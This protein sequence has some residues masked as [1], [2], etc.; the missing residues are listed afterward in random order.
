[1]SKHVQVIERATMHDGYASV[2][3]VKLRHRLFAGGWSKPVTREVVRRGHAVGVLPYDPVRDEVVLIR[4]FRIGAWGDGRDPWLVETVAGIIDEGETAEQVARRETLEECGCTLSDLHRVC[5]YL[6]SPG[7]MT[8]CITLFCGITETAGAGGIH[9][10][11]DEGEDIQAFVAPFD[12]VWADIH[13]GRIVDA[14]LMLVMNW[15][16]HNRESLV[17]RFSRGKDRL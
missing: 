17:S 2:E 1:M 3:R 5:D 9:G 10:L 16:G 7:V 6:A 8:E 11:G 12:E 15:I 14:K 4:Q 13:A